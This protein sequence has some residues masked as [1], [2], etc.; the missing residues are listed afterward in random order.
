MSKIVNDDYRRGIADL[1]EAILHDTKQYAGFN[2]L[3]WCKEKGEDNLTGHER[4]YYDCV[5]AGVSTGTYD[6]LPTMPYLGNETRRVYY[7]S[8]ETRQGDKLLHY[9]KRLT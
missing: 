4:W 5:A 8:T 3:A 9:P 7:K 1:L 2:Y 6:C